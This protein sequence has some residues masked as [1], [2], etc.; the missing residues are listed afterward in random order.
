MIL[1]IADSY[2]M[3][4]SLFLNGFNIQQEVSREM[5]VKLILI[6]LFRILFITTFF[7]KT[8]VLESQHFVV[9]VA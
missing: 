8:S 3:D 7:L 4:M 5:E 1:G 2:L 9:V 6:N